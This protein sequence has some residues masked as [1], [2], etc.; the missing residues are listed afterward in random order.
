MVSNIF[1]LNLLTAM[2]NKIV[3]VINVLIVHH[4]T[5]QH[6]WPQQEQ[7]SFRLKCLYD[8]SPVGL[9]CFISAGQSGVYSNQ[10]DR[11]GY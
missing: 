10:N 7:R 9:E 6:F 1:R 11:Q 2:V 8:G 5:E 3:G 4:K